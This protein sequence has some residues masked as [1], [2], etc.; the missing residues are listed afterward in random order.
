MRRR[1]EE[2]PRAGTAKILMM[3]LVPTGP[4][5]VRDYGHLLGEEL[6]RK[7]VRATEMWVHNDGLRFLPAMAASITLLRRASSVP[8]GTVV[9]WH[10]S[11]FAYAYRGLPLPGVLLGLVLR[12]RRRAVVT[13]LHELAYPWTRRGLVGAAYAATQRVALV[14]V[15]AGSTVAVVTTEQRAR[16][17]R[18]AWWIPRRVTQVVPVFSTIGQEAVPPPVEEGLVRL[19]VIGFGSDGAKPEL[20]FSALSKLRHVALR[21][22][23]LGAPGSESTAGRR[24][25]T[26]ATL[27]GLQNQL[28]FTGVVP[29]PELTKCMGAC[30]AIALIDEEGPTSRRTMLAAA[31]S[32]GRPVISTHGPNCWHDAI[33]KGAILVVPPEADALAEALQ[34]VLADQQERAAMGARAAGYYKS[35]LSLEKCSRAILR[36]IHVAQEDAHRARGPARGPLRRGPRTGRRD[37]LHRSPSTEL[38]A[39]SLD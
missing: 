15:V 24:W 3:G 34:R 5:G 33:H 29:Q 9:V 27:A 39:S 36:L 22:V 19:G 18:R 37:G 31:L 12:A 28:E 11:P 16:W 20:L 13:V 6:G 21:I 35:E 2:T 32:L 26:S 1:T 7:R 4:S 14:G 25:M 10:Y 38:P 17:L 23:L 8:R 30:A